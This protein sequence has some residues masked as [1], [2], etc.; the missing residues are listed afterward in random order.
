LLPIV[1]GNVREQPLAEIYRESKVFKELRQPD[2]YKGKCGVCEFNKVCGGSRSRTYGVTG[3]Y[4]ESE[5]FCVYIPMALRNKE[6]S[7]IA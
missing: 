1:G 4:L 7:P 6:N 3:D 5:P 2:N